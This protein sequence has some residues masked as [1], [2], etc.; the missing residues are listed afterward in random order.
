MGHQPWSRV[1][2]ETARDPARQA[3]VDEMKKAAS[4]AYQLAQLREG[5]GTT[6]VAMASAMGISQGGVSRI[7]HRQDVFLSTLR[8]YVEALGGTLEL[9]A[10]FPDETVEIVSQA[11]GQV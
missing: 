6:Q 5:R 2:E 8:E 4:A 10:V 7:E 1:R 9:R 3:R 11:P